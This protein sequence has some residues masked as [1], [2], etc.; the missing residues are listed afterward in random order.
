MK[1]FLSVLLIISLNA[2]TQAQ[3]RKALQLRKDYIDVAQRKVVGTRM[4]LSKWE[5][6]DTIRYRIQ[7]KLQ[8]L[9][10]KTLGMFLQQV[11]ELTGLTFVESKDKSKYQMLFFFGTLPEYSIYTKIEIPLNLVEKSCTWQSFLTGQ[12]NRLV[13][14]SFC[15]DPSKVKTQLEGRFYFQSLFL[16]SIGICG[17]IDDPMSIFFNCYS[18]KNSGLTMIDKRLIKIHYHPKIKSG[19]LDYLVE[20]TVRDSIDLESLVNA[21]FPI[22]GDL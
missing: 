21:K 14:T 1:I 20:R 15:I 17:N 5:V 10:S 11:H 3:S 7:G 19:M 16:K 12:N 2:F 6:I 9:N 8:Y 18:N 4:P 13:Q 22:R